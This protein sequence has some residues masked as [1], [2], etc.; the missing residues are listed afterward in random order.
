[1]EPRRGQ[2]PKLIRALKKVG[3][4]GASGAAMAG[5]YTGT[6]QLMQKQR[7]KRD[8]INGAVGGFVSGS[9][10]VGFHAKRI[11]LAMAAGGTLAAISAILNIK[12]RE[13][14]DFELVKPLDYVYTL[15][16]KA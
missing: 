4:I 10:V 5:L 1:M 3:V 15:E 11:P 9:L 16:K 6:E 12:Y 14:G 8:Y 7:M 13:N 2:L